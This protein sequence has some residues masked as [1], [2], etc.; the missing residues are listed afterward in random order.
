MLNVELAVGRGLV[1]DKVSIEEDNDSDTGIP[2][3]VSIGGI[4]VS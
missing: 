3:D 1:G 2:V 4:D